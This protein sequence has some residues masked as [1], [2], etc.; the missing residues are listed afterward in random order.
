MNHSKN[1]RG[2]TLIELGV[3]IAAV[4]VLATAVIAT[5]GFIASSRVGASVQMVQTLQRAA[6]AYSER[7]HN[8]LSFED[9]CVENLIGEGLLSPGVASPWDTTPQVFPAPGNEE[10]IITFRVPDR[11]TEDDCTNALKK[12]GDV[13]TVPG[14]NIVRLLTR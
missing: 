1:G 7:K 5:R 12:M 6:R 11:P 10:I 2:F 14:T 13:Q 3:A 4:A 9:V 8:S